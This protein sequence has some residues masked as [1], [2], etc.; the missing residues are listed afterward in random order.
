MHD[1]SGEGA[2]LYGGR[3]NAP[4]MAALYT[5]V[6]LSLAILEKLAHHQWPQDMLHLALG[7]YVVHNT[8]ELYMVDPAQLK[9]NWPQ[10]I[11]YTQWMGKQIF[12]AGYAG[13][14]APSAIVPIE[15][16]LVLH[17]Q[18]LGKHSV[19]LEET[20]PYDI[21]SRLFKKATD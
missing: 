6:H 9:P 12:Q 17:P 8:G 7:T 21:D 11:P 20:T 10:D 3:W 16:N 19:T 4:G 18:R 2:R 15:Y 13:F 5:S 1:T 14:L